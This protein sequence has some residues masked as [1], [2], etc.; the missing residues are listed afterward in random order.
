VWA[1]LFTPLVQ[2]LDSL[3][4][5]VRVQLPFPRHAFRAATA[6]VERWRAEA[7]A[8]TARP[9]DPFELVAPAGEPEAA[10]SRVWTAQGFEAGSTFTQLIAGAMTPAGPL[11]FAWRPTPAVRLPPVLLGSPSTTAPGVLRVWSVAGALFSEQALFA[12]P[13]TGGP[14]SGI[15][16]LFLSWRERRGQGRGTAMALRDLL[17]TPGGAQWPADTT[18]AARWQRAQRL[19]AQAAAA[20]GAGDLETFG[21]RYRELQDLLG[22]GRHT[23]APAPERR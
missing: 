1:R 12:Q 8:W 17:A 5:A 21:R 4:A 6:L 9:R 7:V 13:A 22:A 16:T 18:L 15:D 10:G 23:L 19:A 14:P 20:L 3:P 11:L 2:P